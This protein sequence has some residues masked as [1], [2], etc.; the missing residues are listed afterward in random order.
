MGSLFRIELVGGLG[1]TSAGDY[2]QLQ[3]WERDV[4]LVEQARRFCEH[5]VRQNT[6]E[7]P[8]IR[9]EE[10]VV[11]VRHTAPERALYLGQAH[12]AP[13]M[14]S[15]DTFATEENVRALERLL[16]Q[17][18]HFQAASS[19][20]ADA[21][22]ECHRIEEQKERQVVRARN[23]LERCWQALLLLDAKQ[24]VEPNQDGSELEAVGWR[25]RVDAEL[26]SLRA[27]GV[28]KNI[29]VAEEFSKLVSKVEGDSLQSRLAALDGHKPRDP[30]V[31]A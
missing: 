5:F 30:E 14:H 15:P 11:L 25:P 7:L 2:A 24:K 20:S 12:D 1:S 28:E 19:R 23:Q 16:K 3:P 18:S 29:A 22:E 10:H 27:D 4:F 13:D 26:Q 6:A 31:N 9:L 8:Q 17:C 21:K